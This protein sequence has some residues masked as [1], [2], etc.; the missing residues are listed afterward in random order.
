MPYALALRAFSHKCLRSRRAGCGVHEFFHRSLCSW[1]GRWLLAQ[2]VP[3]V[4]F[5]RAGGGIYGRCDLVWLVGER[6]GT[7]LE[8]RLDQR[9]ELC[10]W[11]QELPVDLADGL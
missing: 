6:G 4:V 7:Q 3:P 9:D 1:D 8:G 10:G 5:Q 11:R 2:D